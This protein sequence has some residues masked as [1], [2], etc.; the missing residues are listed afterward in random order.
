M[1][2]GNGEFHIGDCFDVM[3]GIPDGSVDMVLCDL[4]YGT[5][6][7]KWDAVLP[8]DRLWA[9]YWRVCK[10]NAAVVL[11]AAQPFTSA[12]VMSQI[13]RFRYE[14][15]WKKNMGSGFAS[16][17]FQ[18]M[19]YHESALVFYR[20]RP[21]YNPQPT[22]RNSVASEKVCKRPVRSGARKSNH[23]PMMSVTRQY[24]PKNKG[25]ESVL[26]FNSVPNG[27][28]GKLHPT[29]KPVSLF[30]YLIRTYTHEGM[31]VL[32]NTAGS[33]TTAIAAENANRRWICIE[34]DE[35]YAAKAIERIA[36]HVATPTLV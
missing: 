5:T 19:R 29:Q 1:K 3:A 13:N 30:E 2:I 34:R 25:P 4:P 31:T 15:I 23:T 35:E 11:T 28:G 7:C 21:L 24:D 6:A 36:R 12:L 17:K 18:P 9:E 27:G 20:D 16:A 22:Q 10:P 14:W 26:S 8:F 32:D 33:G